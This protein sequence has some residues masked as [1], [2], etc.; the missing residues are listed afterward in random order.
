MNDR[1]ISIELEDDDDVIHKLDFAAERFRN[2]A[3]ELLDNIAEFGVHVLDANVPVHSSY[4]LR[5]VGRSPVA[6]RP[7]GAGGG[8]EWQAVVG[9]RAGSSRHPLYVERGT[10]IYGVVGFYILPGQRPYM[11]F[12]SSI[13]G[14]LIRVKQVRGQRP[15]RYFYTSWREVQIYAGARLRAINI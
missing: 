2:R 13:Y 5:H 10:G 3:K 1:F 14:H 15:K 7:G 11:V 6:W 12:Y 8:G 4:L 9:I